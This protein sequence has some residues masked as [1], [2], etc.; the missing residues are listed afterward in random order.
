MWTARIGVQCPAIGAE[1]CLDVKAD[2]RALVEQRAV[3]PKP[4]LQQNSSNVSNLERLNW[5]GK[6]TRNAARSNP[7]GAQVPGEFPEPQNPDTGTFMNHSC[8]S[9][10]THLVR[11]HCVPGVVL[12]PE[13]LKPNKTGTVPALV[14]L[15]M[16]AGLKSE[17]RMLDKQAQN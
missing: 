1:Q 11:T 12:G 16:G 7:T 13:N 15:L 5:A 14:E 3:N 17:L 6:F 9:F 10:P 8:H 2:P 4:R